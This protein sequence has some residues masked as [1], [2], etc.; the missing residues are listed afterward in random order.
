[1]I[2]CRDLQADTSSNCSAPMAIMGR[3]PA[4]VV[5]Q[6]VFTLLVTWLSWWI[7]RFKI[8]LRLYPQ[9]PKELPYWILFIGH[10]ASFF[11]G[12]N[13]AVEKGRKHFAPS[14]EPFAMT[15][16]G[17]TVYLVTAAEDINHVWNNTKTI[18]LNPL[19]L[20]L[21]TWINISTKSRKALFERYPEA[22]YKAQHGRTMTPT[23]MA[24]ELQHQQLQKGL[25]LGCSY[26]GQD[27][28]QLFQTNGRFGDQRPSCVISFS[29]VMHGIATWSLHRCFHHRA[30]R[31][32]L[33][34]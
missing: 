13:G 5:A 29:K 20:E 8:R 30:Y 15:V 7:W 3:S 17:Q 2:R 14:R 31:R 19:T 24:I 9:E 32:V 4:T 33:R 22:R 25:R 10:A 34:S 27:F 21:Y 12:F 16:A 28:A 18:S 23:Q 6:L 1:M 26:E 11:M